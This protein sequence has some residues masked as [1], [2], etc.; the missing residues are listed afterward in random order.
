MTDG[1]FPLRPVGLEFLETAS[2]TFTYDAPLAAPPAIVFAAI[3]AD[4]STWSWFPGI[5]TG[6]YEGD[7]A[8]GVGT[9]RWV[10]IGGVKYRETILAWDEPRRWAYRVDE[11]SAPVFAVLV[12][13]WGIEP[14]A[15]GGATL[16]WTFAF[17]PLP[18]TAALFA[19][20]RELIG[21]T[22][23]DAAKGLDD[24]LR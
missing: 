19:G 12:E 14:A 23:H 9:R 8:P 7:A 3:S 11:T 10:R 18:E 1:T 2:H 4:P 5:E 16:R 13:D 24:S 17:E 15:G 22:F 6:E 20:A 21:T